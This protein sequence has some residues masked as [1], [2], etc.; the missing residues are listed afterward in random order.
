MLRKNL[1][2]R[3][4]HVVES[5]VQGY[6]GVITVEKGFGTYPE[7]ALGECHEVKTRDDAEVIATATKGKVQNRGMRNS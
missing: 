3:F 1:R 2:V 7:I 4:I 5:I 6:C